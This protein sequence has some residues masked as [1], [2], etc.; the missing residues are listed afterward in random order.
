MP[1]DLAVLVPV[2]DR[3]QNV[4]PLVRSFLTS[5]TPGVLVFIVE[6]TDLAELEMCRR[7]EPLHRIWVLPVIDAHAWPEKINVG[8]EHVTADWYLCAADDIT[9]TEGWWETTADLRADPRIGVIGTNDSATGTGNPAVAQGQHTCHPLMRRSYI[10]DRGI[11]GEPGKAVCEDYHHWYVDNEIV[12]TAKLREAWAFCRD[13]VLEHNHP[14]WRDG[15]G[16]DATYA[17]G[18]SRAAEDQAT[19]IRRSTEY[20]PLTAGNPH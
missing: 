1:R 20:G 17:K 8:V 15:Q 19:W 7:F 16:W 9:F 13:A 4:E 5:G 2:L 3:P 14:Y 12:V 10:L 11:W 6:I 18:E